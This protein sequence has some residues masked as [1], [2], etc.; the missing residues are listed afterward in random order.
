MMV[1]VFLIFFT[2]GETKQDADSAKC[3][4]CF[5]SYPLFVCNMCIARILHHGRRAVLL[6]VFH[7][8][9]RQ[10]RAMK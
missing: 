10:I 1:V 2:G 8:L 5:H 9:A 4:K 7:F 6:G 3:E